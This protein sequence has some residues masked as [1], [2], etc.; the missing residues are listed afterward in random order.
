MMIKIAADFINNADEEKG[1]MGPV[2]IAP[3]EIKLGEVQ[4]PGTDITTGESKKSKVVRYA[5]PHLV[6]PDRGMLNRLSPFFGQEPQQTPGRPGFH[7]EL[8][9]KEPF[10][11]LLHPNACAILHERTDPTTRTW[12]GECDGGSIAMAGRNTVRQPCICKATGQ[13]TCTTRVT[14][15]GQLYLDGL[16]EHPLVRNTNKSDNFADELLPVAEL[17]D[18]AKGDEVVIVQIG[19]LDNRGTGR[20]RFVATTGTIEAAAYARLRVNAMAIVPKVILDR[21][22]QQDRIGELYAVAYKDLR[23]QADEIHAQESEAVTSERQSPIVNLYQEKPV[24]QTSTGIQDAEADVIFEE[25]PTTD[26][27]IVDDMKPNVNEEPD[28]QVVAS[29]STSNGVSFAPF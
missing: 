7:L 18:N 6:A 15:Q 19:Y 4:S 26:E 23:S 21:A 25:D 20:K 27:T 9:A 14:I 3:I 24:E 10:N 29:R 2:K 11:I 28:S 8:S 22:A 1:R 13:M 5:S 16:H 17:F 12:I